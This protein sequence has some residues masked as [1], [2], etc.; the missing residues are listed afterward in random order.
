MTSLL[1]LMPILSEL[2]DPTELEILNQ[3]LALR[4]HGRLLSKG[5]MR[6]KVHATPWLR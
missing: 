5:E 4:G 6:E 2:A 1:S 3:L